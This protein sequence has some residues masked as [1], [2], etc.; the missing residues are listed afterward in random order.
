MAPRIRGV[1]NVSNLTPRCG[2]K[3]SM[4]SISPSTPELTRSPGSTVRRQPGADPAGDELHQRGVRDDQVVA[5]RRAAPLEP[6]VPLHREVRIDIDDA[7]WC[8]IGVDG[9]SAHRLTVSPASDATRSSK[10]R[11]LMR[12]GW[13]SAYAAR[14]R[15]RLTCV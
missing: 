5:G 8:T 13:A 15:S 12:R 7:H 1:A 14:S 10:T 4:A 3:R 9:A 2:S 11:S 6:A